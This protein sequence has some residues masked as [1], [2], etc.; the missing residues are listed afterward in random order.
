MKLII[1]NV[2]LKYSV[3]LTNNSSK[4][5]FPKINE[6]IFVFAGRSNVGKSSVINSIIGR[7]VAFVSK[8]PGRTKQINYY[9]VNSKFYLVDLP[10]YGYACVSKKEIEA[11]KHLVESFFY[12]QCNI[13]LVFVL[14]DIRRGLLE[15]DKIMFEYLGKISKEFFIVLNKSDKLSVNELRDKISIISSEIKFDINKILPYS[16]KTG[17]GKKELLLNIIKYIFL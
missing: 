1:K 2:E 9:L 6:P 8:L 7:K 10:G 13:K 3:V 14:V 16:V 17:L 12:K 15:Q 11:W 4:L 5:S